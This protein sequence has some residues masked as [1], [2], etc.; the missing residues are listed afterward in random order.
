MIVTVLELVYFLMFS[1]RN[2]Y[3]TDPCEV[4]ILIAI[5][6]LVMFQNKNITFRGNRTN[7]G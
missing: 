4:N 3:S 5:N 6:V 1:I 2:K 7:K